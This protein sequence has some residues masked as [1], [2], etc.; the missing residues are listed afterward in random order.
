MQ[1]EAIVINR[2][3]IVF[4]VVISWILWNNHIHI[5]KTPST[6]SYHQLTY[7]IHSTLTF[8]L[9]IVYKS[10][11]RLM[12][13]LQTVFKTDNITYKPI[14]RAHSTE[15]N[16]I[17]AHNISSWSRDS[18][19]HSQ[20]HHFTTTSYQQHNPIRYIISSFTQNTRW[21]L[22]DHVFFPIFSKSLNHLLEWFD[23]Y[24]TGLLYISTPSFIPITIFHDSIQFSFLSIIKQSNNHS[25]PFSFTH[26][27][28]LPILHISSMD[29]SKRVKTKKKTKDI[30]AKLDRQFGKA[31]MNWMENF[32]FL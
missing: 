24:K 2:I 16:D 31:G 28:L 20:T 26:S 25:F 6:I 23:S 21:W 10:C 12:L 15:F 19:L 32:H 17:E 11:S 7:T 29:K 4:H 9:W 13:S 8:M 14:I 18:K 3:E 1:L 30:L 5:E 27:F 22:M